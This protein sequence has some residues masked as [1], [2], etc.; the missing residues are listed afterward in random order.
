[1]VGAV[2]NALAGVNIGGMLVAR[3]HTGGNALMV[4]TVDSAVDLNTVAKLGKEIG[5]ELARTVS[6]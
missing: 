1:V 5:A 4:I 6:L 2:G 3:D